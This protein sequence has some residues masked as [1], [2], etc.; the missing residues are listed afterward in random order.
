MKS[1][2]PIP[3]IIHYV[4]IIE[5]W[6]VDAK[7]VR[8]ITGIRISFNDWVMFNG[9]NIDKWVNKPLDRLKYYQRVKNVSCKKY[10]N[11]NNN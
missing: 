8:Q 9:V 4:D 5:Q 3:S 7:L 6:K 2:N 11:F 10:A 1:L